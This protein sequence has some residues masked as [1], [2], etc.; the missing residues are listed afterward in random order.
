MKTGI[1]KT[2]NAEWRNWNVT[3]PECDGTGMRRN[4]NRVNRGIKKYLK[5]KYGAK[6]NSASASVGN[7]E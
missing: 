3:E 2:P 6:K 7:V 1:D 5:K 4:R